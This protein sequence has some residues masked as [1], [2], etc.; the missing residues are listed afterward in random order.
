MK[1]QSTESV[2]FGTRAPG[3]PDGTWSRMT[4]KAA[5]PRKTVQDQESLGARRGCP[6]RV[7]GFPGESLDAHLL[8]GMQNS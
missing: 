3:C 2:R 4:A 7:N 5:M 6:R 1:K 8:V